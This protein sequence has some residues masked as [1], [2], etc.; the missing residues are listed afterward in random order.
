MV[1]ALK[2]KSSTTTE[3]Q[4]YRKAPRKKVFW[5]RSGQVILFFSLPSAPT[6]KIRLSDQA[7]PPEIKRMGMMG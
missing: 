7:R 4:R 6:M 3:V 1:G 5:P 2:K